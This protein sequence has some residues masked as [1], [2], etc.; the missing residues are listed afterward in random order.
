MGL[1]SQVARAVARTVVNLAKRA[2]TTFRR[3]GVRE[4]TSPQTPKNT[5]KVEKQP[6][7]GSKV[8]ETEHQKSMRESL[9]ADRM[10]EERQTMAEKRIEAKRAQSQ[11]WRASPDRTPPTP[12]QPEGKWTRQVLSERQDKGLAT[13][14]SGEQVKGNAKARGDGYER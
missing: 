7:R 1:R 12:K 6:M 8:G 4:E 2:W 13:G 3:S 5:L 10:R 14:K 11:S 9:A